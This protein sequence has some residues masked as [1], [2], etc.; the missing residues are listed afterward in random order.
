M[1]EQSDSSETP[2]GL[3]PLL[4]VPAI[5]RG[6]LRVL[7]EAFS[8]SCSGVLAEDLEIYEDNAGNL[9]FGSG[10]KILTDQQT[11]H[12]TT[13]MVAGVAALQHALSKARIEALVTSSRDGALYRVPRFYWWT[14]GILDGDD[15]K[16]LPTVPDHLVGQAIVVDR[17]AEAAWR[18][19]VEAECRARNVAANDDQANPVS[20][21]ESSGPRLNGRWVNRVPS[22]QARLVYEFFELAKRTHLAGGSD[23]LGPV[24]LREKYVEWLRRRYPKA[25][26]FARSSF[27]E[28]LV[29]FEDGW[30]IRADGQGLEHRPD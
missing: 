19:V 13:R 21:R 30:G 10:G 15:L 5:P 14:C 28:A 4:F 24:R 8:L 16:P 2:K 6:E 25:K 18:E 20:K 11:Q 1:V 23:P 26:P 27:E 9:H 7:S 3:G 12:R 17:A 29:R 22:E